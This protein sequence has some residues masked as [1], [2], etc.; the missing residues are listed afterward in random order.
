M[1]IQKAAGLSASL[2]MDCRVTHGLNDS[3]N[4]RRV[5]EPA[6]C[7]QRYKS[8]QLQI[9][10]DLHRSEFSISGVLAISENVYQCQ[11]VKICSQM[12]A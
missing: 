4:G 9:S 10:T 5:R 6:C 11:S 3:W 1:S 8:I 7:V 2:P 12:Q